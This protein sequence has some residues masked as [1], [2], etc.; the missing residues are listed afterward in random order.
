M[1]YFHQKRYSMTKKAYIDPT[2]M[3]LL[4]M[5]L[6]DNQP[7]IQF[8]HEIEESQKIVFVDILIRGTEDSKIDTTVFIKTYSYKTEYQMEA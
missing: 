4:I 7:S 3:K 2:K 5:K 1:K 6:I 8:I